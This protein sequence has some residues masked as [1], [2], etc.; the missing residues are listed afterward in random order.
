MLPWAAVVP[1]KG[2]SRTKSRLQTA[3]LSPVEAI[4]RRDLAHAFAMDTVAALLASSAIGKV[5][6]VTASDRVA[7]DLGGL[8][9]VIVTEDDAAV[10]AR[11][12]LPIEV[13]EDSLN[14]AILLGFDRARRQCP[15]H[16]VVVVT[17]DLPTLDAQA[18]TEL[19][20]VAAQH[21]RAML[22][23][24]EGTGTAMLMMTP[25]PSDGDRASGVGSGG[26]G[27]GGAGARMEP[28]RPRF[29]PGSRA[30]HEGLGH[31]VLDAPARLRRDVDTI[32][33]LRAAA[34]LSLGDYTRAVLDA[35]GWMGA[36]ADRLV[37]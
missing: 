2:G 26:A 12:D 1:V 35:H 29:G 11:S 3:A 19:L 9:A 32:A 7:Q 8:G 31:L 4:D 17:G 36:H 30:A 15:H 28:L 21:R 37:R 23:D 5:F 33:D 10:P 16:G 25:E 20:S 14:R 24:S 13:G 27:S 18:V 34:A 6:V 22:P